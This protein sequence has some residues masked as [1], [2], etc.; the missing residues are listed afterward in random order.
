MAYQKF[1]GDN[2]MFDTINGVDYHITQ[3]D[4][5]T[6]KVNEILIGEKSLENL[7]FEI[8]Q[9]LLRKKSFNK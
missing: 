1:L 5:E 6:R 4:K 8:G 7:Y 2:A 9:E 3:Y